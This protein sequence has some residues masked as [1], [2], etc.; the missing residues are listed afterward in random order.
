M[1]RTL[2]STDRQTG[3]VPGIAEDVMNFFHTWERF[4]LFGNDSSEH[5]RLALLDS[6][7]P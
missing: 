4:V 2:L 7:V 6:N 5:A 1:T 3:R